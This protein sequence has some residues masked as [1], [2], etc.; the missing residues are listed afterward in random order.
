[1]ATHTSVQPGVVVSVVGPTASG[2]TELAIALAQQLDTEIVS[3][4][5]RQVYRS[6]AIGT[7][8]PTAEERAPPR[9]H[10]VDFLEPSALYSAGSFEE[11]AVPLLSRLCS[12]RGSAILAGGSGMYVKAALQGLDAL[13][14]DLTLRTQLNKQFAEEGLAP[15]VERLS[16]LDP[17][18]AQA[19]DTSNPQRVIRALEV[20][21]VSGKPFSSFHTGCGQAPA[22]ARGFC[23]TGPRPRRTQGAHR[24][25]G[26]GHDGR[27]MVGR[28]Q[29]PSAIPFRKRFEHRGIQRV[30]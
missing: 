5:A 14:A 26:A 13:P 8:Q 15:L 29:G 19:M 6:M 4:D 27:W 16:K 18:H 12:D 3:A 30:V 20:C 10:L 28:N 22:L 25:Q 7:A 24:R 21:V 1:M 11:D 23:G 17:S 9:H 2:K